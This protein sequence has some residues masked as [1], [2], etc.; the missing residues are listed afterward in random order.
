LALKADYWEEVINVSEI[1][2]KTMKKAKRNI[3][4]IIKLKKTLK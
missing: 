3:I 2:D 1:M 4:R